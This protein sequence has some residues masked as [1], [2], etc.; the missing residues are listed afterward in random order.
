MIEYLI[1]FFSALSCVLSAAAFGLLRKVAKEQSERELSDTAEL[2]ENLNTRL[3]D[4][5][6]TQFSLRM[7]NYPRPNVV[8]RKK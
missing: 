8:A 6:M 1:L 2:E 5:Q 7:P 4:L 3:R